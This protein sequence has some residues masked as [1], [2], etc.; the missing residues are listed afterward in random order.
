LIEQGRF[1][2]RPCFIMSFAVL[3]NYS[4][5]GFVVENKTIGFSAFPG[6]KKA[7]CELFN[8]ML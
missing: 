3:S 6:V 2:N 1:G 8:P 5:I 4:A 7:F